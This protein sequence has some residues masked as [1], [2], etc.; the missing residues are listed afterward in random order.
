[1]IILKLDCKD[2][3]QI[4]NATLLNKESIFFKIT[5]K[6]DYIKLKK[7][8]QKIH[9]GKFNGKKIVFTLVL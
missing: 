4:I 1:M 2:D 5:N 9:N 8:L 7:D 6:N 3:L